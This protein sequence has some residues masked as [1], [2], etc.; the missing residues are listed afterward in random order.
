MGEAD[1]ALPKVFQVS[2]YD[3]GMRIWDKRLGKRGI[4]VLI[5]RNTMLPATHSTKF[6]TTR[7]D[8]QRI[9]FEL[10]QCKGE[11]K[12]VSLGNF[13]FGPIQN[14]RKNYPVELTI[15]YD[16]EGMV[17]VTARDLQTGQKMDQVWEDKDQKQMSQIAFW[18][19]RIQYKKVFIS[20]LFCYYWYGMMPLL[21]F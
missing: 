6:Y 15:V 2:G 10:V 3:L 9:V 20:P 14:P 18:Q 13:A 12:E 21:F 8:Q 7:D 4:Q 11:E 16:A 5:P 19:E 1:F 17:K